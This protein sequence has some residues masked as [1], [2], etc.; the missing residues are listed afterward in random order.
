MN[1][2]SA[3]RFHVTGRRTHRQVMSIHHQL[4]KKGQPCGKVHDYLFPGETRLHSLARAH[5]LRLQFHGK[6][7]K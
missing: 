6:D 7:A 5:R 3:T 1:Q 4:F 2:Q